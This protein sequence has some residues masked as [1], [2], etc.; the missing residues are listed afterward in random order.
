MTMMPVICDRRL[1]SSRRG[2][3][4]RKGEAWQERQ[5]SS[6]AE[7]VS[8]GQSFLSSPEPILTPPTAATRTPWVPTADFISERELPV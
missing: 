7:A 1:E 6:D 4:E 2:I 3:F 8:T 5:K